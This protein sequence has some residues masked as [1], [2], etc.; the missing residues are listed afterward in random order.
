[1]IE[2]RRGTSRAAI[3]LIIPA[4]S[5]ASIFDSRK[6]PLAIASVPKLFRR[7]P[8]G[9]RSVETPSLYAVWTSGRDLGVL[10]V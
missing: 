4:V 2:E 10:G 9:A 7:R 8:S 3:P 1:M 5:P 6:F